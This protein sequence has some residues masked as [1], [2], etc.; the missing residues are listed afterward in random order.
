MRMANFDMGEEYLREEVQE[1]SDEDDN[2]AS[3]EEDEVMELPADDGDRS[4]HHPQRSP[5]IR[6][7]QSMQSSSHTHAEQP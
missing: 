1:D 2:A 4:P 7:S 6:R 3:E 5:S